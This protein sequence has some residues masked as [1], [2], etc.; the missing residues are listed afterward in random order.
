MGGFF[1]PSGVNCCRCLM[2]FLNP[3]SDAD[4]KR[5]TFVGSPERPGICH[6]GQMGERRVTFKAIGIITDPATEVCG[7]LKIQNGMLVVR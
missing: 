6:S 2:G 5:C 1:N 3:T 7:Y 4:G